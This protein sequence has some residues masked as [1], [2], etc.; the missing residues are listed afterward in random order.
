MADEARE[1]DLGRVMVVAA[2]VVLIVL[3]AA[4][5]TSLLPAHLQRAIFYG[6]VLIVVLILG[7]AIVLWRIA[8][9]RPR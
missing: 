9:S 5:G 8:R 4:V 1:A 3:G 2:A 7:T 6:P